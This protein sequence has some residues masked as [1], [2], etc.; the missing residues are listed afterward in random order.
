MG[1]PLAK[2]ISE[3]LL[4]IDLV[5]KRLRSSRTCRGITLEQIRSFRFCEQDYY[6]NFEYFRKT[7]G[8]VHN[9]AHGMIN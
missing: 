4:F 2:E 6:R 1:R 3:Y 9:I 8:A 7:I 5:F